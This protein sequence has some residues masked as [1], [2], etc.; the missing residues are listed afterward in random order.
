MTSLALRLLQHPIHA[1][2]VALWLARGWWSKLWYPARGIRF[3]AGRN[4]RVAGRLVIRGPGR[5]I[6]GD[7]VRVEGLVTPWTYTPEAVIRI[8]SDSYLN[9][10]RFGCHRQ[11]TVG[12]RAI[13]ADARLLD[14]DFHSAHANRHDPSAPV[15][16]APIVLEENVWVAAAAGILPG[17]TI[18]RNSVVGFGAVCA[19]SYPADVIITGNPARVVRPIPSAAQAPAPGAASTANAPAHSVEARPDQPLASAGDGPR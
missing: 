11:I 13:L 14:T 1:V 10:T 9:G 17:T 16:V 6:F 5:V 19:G 2:R 18:G 7:N 15:R 12:P 8:G 4:L 3:T